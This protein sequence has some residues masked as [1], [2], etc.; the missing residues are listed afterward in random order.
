VTLRESLV[1]AGPGISDRVLGEMYAAD[2][3]WTARFGDRGRRHA[4]RDGEFHIQYLVE[5]VDGGEHVFVTYARWLREV[6]VTRGMCSRHLADNFERLA[7]A[8]EAEPW[9]ERARASAILHAGA[10]A[11]VHTD[12]DAGAIDARR[13]ELTAAATRAA[14]AAHPV[15]EPRWRE[16]CAFDLAHHVSYLA[17]A[18]A[19]QRGE[20]FANHAAFM[21][22]FLARL[23]AP[24]IML[25]A[26]L[27]ALAG[28]VENTRAR[29]YLA[30]ARR[31]IR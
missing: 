11:L 7:A 30:A 20:L 14:C 28:A 1:A 9:P 25:D 3:F 21:A 24:P 26:S 10:A 4:G 18:L 23:A 12:G 6:L 17:D 13:D 15:W 8:I 5:A 22:G 2:P 27:E 31:A 16:R 29:D 19:V